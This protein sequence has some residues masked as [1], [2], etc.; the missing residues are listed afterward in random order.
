MHRKFCKDI[1]K[2]TLL[3]VTR[4]RRVNYLTAGERPR[5]VGQTRRQYETNYN[6]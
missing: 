1:Q 4:A 3:Y 6:L 2:S 5:G